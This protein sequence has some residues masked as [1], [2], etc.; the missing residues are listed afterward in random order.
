MPNYQ[1]SKIYCIRSHQC[2]DV[3]IG[4]TTLSLA[5]RLAKHRGDY[6]YWKEGKKNWITSF[7]ILKYEDAYIE[8]LEKYPCNDKEELHVK[9]GQFIRKTENCVNRCIAGRTQKEWY[10]ENKEEIN[11]KHKEYYQQNKEEIKDKARV[12]GNNN[13]EKITRY[14]KQYRQQHKEEIA[15]KAKVKITCECGSI[16]NKW[17]IN[18]HRKTKKHQ[19]LLK[20]LN[21]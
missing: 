19:E 17:T 9:E 21:L 12:Y 11:A 14:Q 13:K 15:E 7:Q 1:N 10:Q 20:N 6:K 4:S 16:I 5:Q 18:R 8:L 3:Y 2:D